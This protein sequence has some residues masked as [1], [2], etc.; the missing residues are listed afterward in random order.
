ER[1]PV[2]NM[3]IAKRQITRAMAE[4]APARE[5]PALP[6]SARDKSKGFVDA[7][8]DAKQLFKELPMFSHL[9]AGVD[10][11]TWVEEYTA[12]PQE[13]RRYLTI[14]SDGSARAWVSVPAGFRITEPG[15]DYVA[16]I[17]TDADDVETVRVYSLTRR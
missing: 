14:G 1:R 16:G 17:H 15:R 6:E 13:A 9:I 8:Y 3:P 12:T 2:V 4:A 5:L 10:G 7:R 11:E